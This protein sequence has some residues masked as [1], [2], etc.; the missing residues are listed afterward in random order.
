M[1]D[2]Q[3][4]DMLC[5]VARE[6]L[7]SVAPNELPIFPVASN[8]YF[9]NPASALKQATSRDSPPHT[10]TILYLQKNQCS[11]NSIGNEATP[12]FP[13]GARRRSDRRCFSRAT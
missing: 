10:R 7:I 4:R 6:V 1:D 2:T 13:A 3:D 5:E 11:R 8:M 9:A 12:E